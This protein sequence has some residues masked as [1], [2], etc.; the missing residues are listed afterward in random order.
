MYEAFFGFERP[1]F[2]NVPDPSFVYP[3]AQHQ[4]ALSLLEY[5]IVSR[6]GF[7]VLTGDVGTGKTTMVRRVL[8]GIDQRLQVGLVTNTQCDSFEEFLQWIM[9]AFDLDYRGKQKVEMYDIFVTFLIERFRRGTPVTLI[10][11]EAQ[12]L[13]AR[14][15]EQLRMLSNVNTEKGQV[16]QTILIGQPELWDL[17][18]QPEL[19]QFAQRISY[20]YFLGP[21][22][23]S[24]D[25]GD[26]IRYR[27][28][29]A[30]GRGD[31]F[32]AETFGV[33]WE[34]TGGVPRLINL[35]CDASLL[36]AYA[37]Q[38]SSVCGRIVGDVLRDK[39]LG[40]AGIG[41]RIN[42]SVG[43]PRE[44]QVRLSTI[45]RAMAKA[46]KGSY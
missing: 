1:P 7:C 36:Y 28:D 38:R 39:E 16:L 3:S 45:E 43:T 20:D 11:D 5:A 40:F 33:I 10:V 26:Y 42:G 14:Y 31:V 25:V 34:A 37:E 35:V 19:S 2:A 27:I 46:N 9:L 32:A 13:G 30:G 4:R 24:Q 6:G 21:L 17:L 12:H 8:Q 29:R 15:L 18:R 44:V 23:S 41:T 22:Q